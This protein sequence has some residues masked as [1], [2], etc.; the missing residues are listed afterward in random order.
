MHRVILGSVK[1]QLVDHKNGNGLD[2]R[3]E[4][5][6][7]CTHGQNCANVV[8]KLSQSSSKYKGVV[9]VAGKVSPWRARITFKGKVIYLGSYREEKDA[10]VAYNRAALH[11]FKDFAKI[12]VF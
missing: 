3:K 7:H 10:G 8:K 5:I 12:N 4:N 1:G 6:R 9:Y 11:Y 2:N